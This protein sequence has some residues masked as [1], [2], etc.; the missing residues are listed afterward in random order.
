MSVGVTLF[1]T[2][3]SFGVMTHCYYSSSYAYSFFTHLLI[4]LLINLLTHLLDVL[5][6]PFDS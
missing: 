2:L 4:H 5:H 6:Y 1:H 3:S